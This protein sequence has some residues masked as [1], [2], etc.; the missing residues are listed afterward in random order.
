MRH[1]PSVGTVKHRGHE[2][3][4]AAPPSRGCCIM[5]ETRDLSVVSVP[6]SWTSSTTLTSCTRRGTTSSTPGQQATATFVPDHAE[7]PE[8]GGQLRSESDA[9]DH[10]VR[11]LT[12]IP[13]FDNDFDVA[14]GEVRP[15]G[16]LPELPSYHEA[17]RLPDLPHA[18]LADV[19]LKPFTV[20]GRTMD[21]PLDI[22]DDDAEK[23]KNKSKKRKYRKWLLENGRGAQPG[24][25]PRGLPGKN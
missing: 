4:P 9:R 1:P 10:G 25:V 23:P 18:T 6:S 19:Q 5:A 17:C 11:S 14:P 3:N 13:D 22:T 21:R 24:Y 15:D 16:E 2:G 20:T 7:C 8:F 12:P